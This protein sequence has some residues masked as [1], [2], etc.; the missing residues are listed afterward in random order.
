MFMRPKAKKA[1]AIFSALLAA[2]C[3]VLASTN[4]K[5]PV[6]AA[7]SGFGQPDRAGVNTLTEEERKAGWH[8]LFDGKTT[9][10]WHNFKSPDI[11]P[12]WQIKDGTLTCAD[13][14]NAGDIVTAGKYDWFELS[15][16][17]NMS[18]GG[19]SGI[20]FH[21]TD[22]GR[23][24]WQTGPEIQLLDNKEGKDPNKAGWLY[25]IYTTDTDAT[26]PAGEWNQL[27]ILISPE[28]C[29]HVMNGVKYF[30]YVLG[31]EDFNNRVA[32]SKFGKM[33]L[34]AKSDIGYI[35]L[36]GDHGEVSFRNIKIR[37][38]SYD[39]KPNQQ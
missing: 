3:A 13:P 18:T 28:K 4:A 30:E 25:Q 16:E 23:A 9:N 14:H 32:K 37:P 5:S 38:I 17:Y 11:R 21:A 10:G 24:A 27:R 33:P 31:S 35:A 12:G 15:L 19:N 7:G 36:Q 8:L 6:A 1:R 39:K 26:K 29:E 22:E 34:F 2:G 20:I